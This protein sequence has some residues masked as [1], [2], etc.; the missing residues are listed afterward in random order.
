VYAGLTELMQG[1]TTLLI[2]HRLS[3]AREADLIYLVQDGEVV[4]RGTHDELVSNS[5]RYALL[6]HQG[7]V[8]C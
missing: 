3:T 5:R 1:R 8:A 7:D 6:L 2:A 4:E